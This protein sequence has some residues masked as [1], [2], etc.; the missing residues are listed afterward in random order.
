MEE[1]DII[2]A[3]ENIGLID[4]STIVEQARQRIKNGDAPK[5]NR[6]GE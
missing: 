1:I 5:F 2:D 3:E 6:K 4:I